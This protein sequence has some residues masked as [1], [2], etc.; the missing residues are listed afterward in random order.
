MKQLP[1][2]CPVRS[3]DPV[4]KARDIAYVRLG[5]KNLELAAEYYQDFGLSTFEVSKERILFRGFSSNLPCWSLEKADRDFLLGLGLYISSAEEF[6]RLR[7]MDGA[8]VRPLGRF[9]SGHF[10][11]VTIQDPSGLPV[12]AV[13]LPSSLE[14]MERNRRSRNWN[15][16][17]KVTRKNQP[18]P[19]DVGPAK[20]NRL[21]HAVFLKQE[22]LKNAQWY[23]D[24]FGMI[25]SDIQILPE[26]KEPVIAF[27]RCDLGEKLTDHHTIVIASGIDDRLEHCAFELEDL[28]EVAKGREWLLRRGWKPAWGIGRHIL[29]SQIFDY[30]R[31]PSGMLVEHYTDGDKFDDTVPV[32]FHPISR[33]S[34][35]QWGQDMPEDFLDT[36]L[37]VDKLIQL[38]KGIFSGRKIELKR[39]MELK[40]VAELSPRS[41]IKY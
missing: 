33:E 29:G 1:S 14:E 10:P 4:S 32:G 39:L 18:Q 20:V 12:D 40:K 23:C 30:Q 24:V 11:T 8:E 7:R 36:E 22:F 26:S 21:G 27:L 17:G 2:E 15:S 38:V 34:L 35:Y 28:D 16:D 41:W 31:D 19:Y 9:G 37:S 25:P 6:E 3:K 5:R 13:L